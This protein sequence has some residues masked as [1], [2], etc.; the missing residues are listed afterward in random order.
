MAGDLSCVVKTCSISKDQAD[1]TAKSLRFG[2]A[3]SAFAFV[4]SG[5]IERVS[6]PIPGEF[7]VQNAMAAI[8]A[9]LNLG[10]N[11]TQA[12]TLL[13]QTKGVPGRFQVL[14]TTAP[15]TVIR[16]YA[17]TPDAIIKV[18]SALR[19]VTRARIVTVFGCAG[20]RDR[21]KRSKMAS[22]AARLSDYVVL[23]SDNP[24]DEDEMQ[25]I[26]DAMPGLQANNTPFEVIPDRYEA[27]RWALTHARKGDVLLLAGKGHEDYQVLKHATICFG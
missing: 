22:A 7:S 17:H 3:G 19:A 14:K 16:D 24:R 13:G 4:G 23:T 6:L 5:I 1:Y 9:C 2:E 21:D 12:C 20:R 25:I 11:L 27:I 10:I 15:F 18:L 8:A 26:G